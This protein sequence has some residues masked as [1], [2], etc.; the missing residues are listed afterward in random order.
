MLGRDARALGFEKGAEPA[1]PLAV[2]G[3]GKVLLF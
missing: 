3:V 2:T 1:P